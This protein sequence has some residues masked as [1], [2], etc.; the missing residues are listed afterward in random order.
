MYGKKRMIR[1]TWYL[2]LIEAPIRKQTSDIVKNTVDSTLSV[3]LF[4][5]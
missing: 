1:R 2:I 3:Q 5:L 4:V